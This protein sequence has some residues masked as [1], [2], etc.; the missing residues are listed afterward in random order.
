MNR[1]NLLCINPTKTKAVIFRA[2]NKSVDVTSALK[3]GTSQVE[4]VDK[5]KFLG[6]YFQESLLWD[7]HVNFVRSKLVSTTGRIHR[8]KYIL[9]CH[10]KITLY[11]RCSYLF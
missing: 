5:V 6:V 3:L 10:V 7:V 8:F 4:I 11:I 2:K 9:P 1:K